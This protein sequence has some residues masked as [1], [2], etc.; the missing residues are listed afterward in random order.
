MNVWPEVDLSMHIQLYCK[1]GESGRI[2]R[3]CGAATDGNPIEC[4]KVE[5]RSVC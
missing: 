2:G 1:S 3:E 4:F 5:K